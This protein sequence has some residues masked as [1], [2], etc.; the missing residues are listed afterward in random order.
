MEV[1]WERGPA[2][3]SEVVEAVSSSTPLAYSTVLTTLRILERK[4]YVWHEKQGR[5]YL[6]HPAVNR[7]EAR[8]RAV[9]YV[10]SRF[11]QDSP[12]LLLLN[13]IENEEIHSGELE[14]LKELL[15]EKAERSE[16]GE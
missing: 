14:R 11:F 2:T 12:G 1:L 16:E 13:V 3:V 4:G 15:E 9:R 10:L 7:S 5:A 6:Y 8:R